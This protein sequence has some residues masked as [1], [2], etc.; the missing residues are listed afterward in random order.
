LFQLT[1]NLEEGA[2][3]SPRRPLTMRLLAFFG[4]AGEPAGTKFTSVS[5]AGSP[6][7]RR[8]PAVIL[9]PKPLSTD[10]TES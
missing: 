7:A 1:K 9:P 8:K 3:F 6:R 10:P 2:C 4:G 5:A